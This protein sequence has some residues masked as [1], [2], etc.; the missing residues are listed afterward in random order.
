MISRLRSGSKKTPPSKE[1]IID[2]I[3][4]FKPDSDT[5]GN[6]IYLLFIK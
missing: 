2:T 5:E 6:T 1:D 4:K 3:D